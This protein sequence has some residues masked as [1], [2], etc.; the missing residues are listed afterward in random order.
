MTK[1]H[2]DKICGI[3]FKDSVKRT[4][5]LLFRWWKAGHKVNWI[6]MCCIARFENV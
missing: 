5:F 2:Q 6:L 3:L 4:F 1:F